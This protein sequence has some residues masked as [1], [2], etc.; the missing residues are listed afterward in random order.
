MDGDIKADRKDPTI[1]KIARALGYKGRKFVIRPA[2]RV[3]LSGTYWDGGS[4]TEWFFYDL[5]SG[6]V[7]PV[8]QWDPPQFGGPRAAPSGELPVGIAAVAHVIFCGK[9]VGL[10]IH[11]RPQ[12]LAKCLPAAQSNA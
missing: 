8:P 3:T 9:D 1:D 12:D 10:K 6:R 2:E 5:P 7:V 11:V 4:R